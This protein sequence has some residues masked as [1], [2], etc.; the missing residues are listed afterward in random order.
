MRKEKINKKKVIG[1]LVVL[2]VMIFLSFAFLKRQHI[3]VK[4]DGVMTLE[5]GQKLSNQVQDYLDLKFFFPFEKE[6]IS[7]QTKIQWDHLDYIDEKKKLVNIGEYQGPLVYDTHKYAIT[8]KVEDTTAP[9]IEC[10]EILPYAKEDFQIEDYIK[11]SDNSYKECQVDIDIQT[12]D[13]NKLGEY[14]IQVTATDPYKNQTK[15]TFDVE[16]A[17]IDGPA[18]Q[19]VDKTVSYLGEKFDPLENVEAIDNLDG[20]CTDKIQV[21]GKVDSQKAGVY[22]LEYQVEDKH[23]NQNTATREVIVLKESDKVKNVPMILQM[24]TYHNGCESASSTML[25]NYYGYDVTLSQV[26]KSVPTIPL[27]THNHRLYGANPNEAFTGSMSKE[28]YGIFSKPMAKVVQK[29]IDQKGGKHQ[30]ENITG[31]SVEELFAYINQGKPVQ[32]WA[33]VY[34]NDFKYSSHK[35]WYI[36]TLDGKYTDETYTFKNSEHSLLLV[37]YTKNTVIMNDPLR[38][39]VEYNREAFQKAYEVMGKQALILK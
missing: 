4:N 18:F 11:V 20:N 31:A 32:V 12:L 23:G 34:M 19:N 39:T 1:V 10:D 30:V 24:P 37:G 29:W 26:V 8:L 5:V 6:N 36:K 15:E 35:T 21:N 9:Q 28:G 7:Q 22:H 14:S 38:G 16:V 13:I 33:S 27:E 2:G 3:D 25:L 17:D